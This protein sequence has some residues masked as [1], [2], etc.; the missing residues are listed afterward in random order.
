MRF[1]SRK[2]LIIRCIPSTLP[3]LFI[4]CCIVNWILLSLLVTI[5]IQKWCLVVMI[6]EALSQEW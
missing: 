1:L 5:W 3:S 6:Q 2:A 4:V